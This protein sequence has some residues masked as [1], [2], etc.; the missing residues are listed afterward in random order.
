M[1]ERKTTDIIKREN[2]ERPDGVMARND[3][4]EISERLSSMVL[5]FDVI[6]K[7]GLDGFWGQNYCSFEMRCA[8]INNNKE[9]INVA[10]IKR[11][12]KLM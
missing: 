4:L 3:K 12:I 5:H 8:I 7:N 6:T 9:N 2:M 1:A 10:L 11:C